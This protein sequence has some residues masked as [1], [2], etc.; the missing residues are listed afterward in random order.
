MCSARK[1]AEKMFGMEAGRVTKALLF[2]FL[3]VAVVAASFTVADSGHALLPLVVNSTG[4]QP[5]ANNADN[6]CDIDLLTTGEQCTLRAAIEQANALPEADNIT[7]AIPGDGPHIIA[8]ASDLPS[9]TQPVTIDGYTETLDET[10]PAAP[11]TATVGTNAK[12]RVEL[13]GGNAGS[14]SSGL[15]ILGSSPS[16][17]V[18]RGLVINN[19]TR[20]I[21]VLENVSNEQPTGVKIEGNF[22]GTDASGTVDQ[23]NSDEGV[24]VVG[25]ANII[26]G[27]TSDKRNL[28]SGNDDNGIE[29][30]SPEENRVEGNLI[31]T[32]ANGTKPLGNG[33]DGVRLSF[34]S[35]NNTVGDDDASDGTTNAANTIAFNG[36]DGVGVIVGTGNRVL[37]N[38]IHSN[39]GLGIDLAGG[40]EDANGVTKN[41]KKD[42]DTGSNDLQN[43]PVLTRAT[44][45][46]TT[47]TIKGTLNS[48]PSTTFTIQFFSNPKKDTSGFG[49]GRTFLGEKTNVTTDGDGNA[50]FTFVPPQR[51]PRGQFITATATDPEGNTSEFSAVRKVQRP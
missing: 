39:G 38:S 47:T 49:E 27:D 35:S 9:I 10:T 20:G 43:F 25:S 23:G 8:P 22:I 44:T 32:K 41:D 7:F 2:G 19:F 5:D 15:T 24:V 14:G 34:N 50:T 3:L 48:T 1:G 29:I 18:V 36:S 40:T 12:L 51:V 28:I 31:G 13:R 26:G 4:D 6:V 45:K 46:G 17:S 30:D 37:S 42:P 16:N 21:G 33:S 11:N